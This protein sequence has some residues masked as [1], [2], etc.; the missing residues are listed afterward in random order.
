MDVYLLALSAPMF[1][2]AIIASAYAYGVVPQLVGIKN[3]NDR[4]S[5]NQGLII[6]SLMISSFFV[7]LLFFVKF[8]VQLYNKSNINII[9]EHYILFKLAWLLGA[10]QIMLTTFGTILTAEKRYLSAVVLQIS[11]QLG[12]LTV[13]LYYNEKQQIVYALIGSLS[14]YVF[15]LCISLLGG[16]KYFINIKNIKMNVLLPIIKKVSSKAIF[17]A[18]AS[19]VFGVYVIIDATMAPFEGSGILASLTYAQKIVIGF[20]NIAV[21]G[22]FTVAAPQFKEI[23]VNKGPI[24]FA[25]HARKLVV[26]TLSFS[27]LIGISLYFFTNVLL[28]FCFKS[29]TFSDEDVSSVTLLV[30]FMLPGMVAML[31]SAV[32]FKALF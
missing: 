31:I 32:L 26:H 11:P 2:S 5:L 12:L 27:L 1:I 21:M 10:C 16:G 20:G 14:G 6:L 19:S 18:I 4:V 3:E 17:G 28:E 22:V 29:E 23:L 9:E 30:R 15:G 24:H 8:Q 25:A 7:L 13:L